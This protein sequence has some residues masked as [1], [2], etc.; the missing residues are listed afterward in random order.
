MSPPSPTSL[1]RPRSTF[2]PL[3]W[4]RPNTSGSS[5]VV[6]AICP[7]LS[8]RRTICR[9][10]LPITNLYIRVLTSLGSSNNKESVWLSDF[11]SCSTSFSNPGRDIERR[12]CLVGSRQCPGS[13]EVCCGHVYNPF[14]SGTV[15]ARL[16]GWRT[17]ELSELPCRWLPRIKA[18]W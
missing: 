7:N 6:Q 12:R 4:S 8:S 11:H 15:R 5:F 16:R 9:T 1:W 18:G 17:D 3:H 2:V 10:L 13:I 14:L